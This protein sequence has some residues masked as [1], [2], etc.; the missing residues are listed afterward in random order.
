MILQKMLR[1]IGGKDLEENFKRAAIAASKIG[2]HYPEP[3]N[4]YNCSRHMKQY[5]YISSIYTY[6]M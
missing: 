5:I 1:V 6:H 2:F 4:P 3:E